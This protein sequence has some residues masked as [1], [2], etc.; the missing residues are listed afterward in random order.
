MGHAGQDGV[1]LVFAYGSNMLK[2]RLAARCPNA[3]VVGVAELA[4]YRLAWHK[5]SSDGSGKCDVVVSEVDTA[6][7]GVVYEV[8]KTEKRR[9]DRAE[10]LGAGYEER[11]VR[12]LLRGASEDVTL[13]AATE[14]DGSLRPFT[15]YRDLVIAGAMEHGL[16]GSYI[17]SLRAV[18]AIEDPDR[19]RHDKHMALIRKDTSA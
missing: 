7:F 13:Y 18:V 3:A 1:T 6:V 5:R 8:S 9:L 14:V 17:E 12:V 19:A 11:A 2:S 10:G 15:W 4:G 16:P